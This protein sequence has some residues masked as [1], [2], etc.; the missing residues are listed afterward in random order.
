MPRPGVEPA[1]TAE[2]PG[3]IGSRRSMINGPNARSAANCESVDCLAVVHLRGSGN[4][5][6]LHAC[7]QLAG[8][9]ASIICLS[10]GAVSRRRAGQLLAYHSR[11]IGT[12]IKATL[13]ITSFPRRPHCHKSINKYAFLL[14]ILLS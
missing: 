2:Q 4:L 6:I 5:G 14:R 10:E 9:R 3:C 1:A 8:C 7:T 13:W 11:T 12:G